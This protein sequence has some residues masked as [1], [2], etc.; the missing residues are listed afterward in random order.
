MLT[1][2]VR[3]NSSIS[4]GRTIVTLSGLGVSSLCK[5]PRLS[6]PLATF[7]ALSPCD[8]V[9]VDSYKCGRCTN[10]QSIV[11]CI[12]SVENDSYQNQETLEIHSKRLLA[13]SSGSHD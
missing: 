6:A 3:I 1:A 4:I 9:A 11:D 5:L 2:R 8:K 7:L 13:E 10:P 12:I